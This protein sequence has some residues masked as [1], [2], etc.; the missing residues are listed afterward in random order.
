MLSSC[1]GITR[2]HFHFTAH[3]RPEAWKCFYG[4][5]SNGPQRKVL[6]KGTSEHGCTSLQLPAAT[7]Y[8]Q[9]L[10][11][12]LPWCSPRDSCGQSHQQQH[13]LF[14]SPSPC[15]QDGHCQGRFLLPLQALVLRLEDKGSWQE[16]RA[17][18]AASSSAH[19]GKQKGDQ[20][21]PAQQLCQQTR[22]YYCELRS[23]ANL[24]IWHT[25][26]DLIPDCKHSQGKSFC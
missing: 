6:G 16:G 18:A 15:S 19:R 9:N 1:G 25:K 8:P 24:A 23:P 4:G 20:G 13:R 5:G 2:Q 26:A 12:L 21:I 22:Q 3:V 14:A 10:C 7:T 11:S 17:G